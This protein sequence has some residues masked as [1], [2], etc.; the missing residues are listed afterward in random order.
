MYSKQNGTHSNEKKKLFEFESTITNQNLLF[1]L[2]N[3]DRE[4]ICLLDTRPEDVFHKFKII[5]CDVINI[6]KENLVPG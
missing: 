4:K 1:L 3:T 5:A 2:E 6:P